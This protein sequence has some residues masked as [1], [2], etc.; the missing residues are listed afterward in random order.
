MVLRLVPL[1]SI[2]SNFCASDSSWHLFQVLHTATRCTAAC[3]ES[4]DSSSTSGAGGGDGRVLRKGI[5][6]RVLSCAFHAESETSLCYLLTGRGDLGPVVWH[7]VACFLP[8]KYLV[9]TYHSTV[10]THRGTQ[11]SS[12]ANAQ[13]RHGRQYSND[14]WARRRSHGSRLLGRFG[15]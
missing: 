11:L 10:S 9:G 2:R 7:S 4:Y 3:Y 5:L 15:R 6:S 12:S 13:D 14:R 8:A 1:L